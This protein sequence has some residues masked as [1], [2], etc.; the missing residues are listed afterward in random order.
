VDTTRVEKDAVYLASVL[1]KFI[2][3]V[4]PNN[5][6]QV[7]TDNIVVNPVAWNL[8]SSKYLHIFFQGCMVHAL[9]LMLKDFVNE[10]W[11]KK[12]VE[13]AQKIVKFIKRRHMPLV[14]F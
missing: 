10:D 4:G 8:I 12:Q 7:T 2:K 14:V 3:K 11:I 1:E 6:V 13:I 9:N 5:I